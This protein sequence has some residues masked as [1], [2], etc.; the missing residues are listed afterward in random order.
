MCAF[1]RL[2]RV[3]N[4]LG[5]PSY[6][7]GLGVGA[8]VVAAGRAHAAPGEVKLPDSECVLFCSFTRLSLSGVH[9]LLVA[10][11]TSKRLSAEFLLLFMPS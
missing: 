3:D 8:Q 2:P 7:T 11:L 10:Q 1:L 6:F 5:T 4:A 9:S